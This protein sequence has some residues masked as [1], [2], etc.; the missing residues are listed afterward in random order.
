VAGDGL[1][2]A[3]RRARRAC[4]ARGRAAAAAG[5]DSPAGPRSQRLGASLCGQR[6][7]ARSLP[8]SGGPDARP[9]SRRPGPPRPLRTVPLAPLPAADA[10][11]MLTAR[12]AAAPRRGAGRA[13][14]ARTR[15]PLPRLR[16]R[17]PARHRSTRGWARKAMQARRPAPPPAGH[18]PRRSP[19]AVSLGALVGR[20][21][22]ARAHGD[23]LAGQARAA[24][25]EGRVLGARGKGGLE[26]QVGLGVRAQGASRHPIGQARHHSPPRPSACRRAR[27]TIGANVLPQRS[28]P[29]PPPLPPATDTLRRAPPRA[30]VSQPLTFAAN[31][32][33]QRLSLAEAGSG[34]MLTAGW[35][36]GAAPAVGRCAGGGS[37]PR[38]GG[39]SCRGPG[40]SPDKQ[41]TKHECL[42]IAAEAGLRGGGERARRR[43][44]GCRGGRRR[45]AA[46]PAS[47]RRG[48]PAPHFSHSPAAGR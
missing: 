23:A 31:F 33:E 29:P 16:P 42:A 6:A 25:V 39:G 2:G 41:P 11:E 22:R 43:G 10:H 26:G 48:R 44:W 3:V 1:V 32:R 8:R 9:P 5:G 24:R 4:A 47:R 13:A 35:A 20:A 27:R 34:L 38:G 17:R 28:P 12:N 14:G 37:G 30:P 15:H 19:Q 18:A 40:L 45:S 7:P 36:G 46:K 21:L